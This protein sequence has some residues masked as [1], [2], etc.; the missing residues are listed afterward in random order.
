MV[1]GNGTRHG[2]GTREQKNRPRSKRASY[3]SNTENQIKEM[4]K[5]VQ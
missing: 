3:C 1:K 5:E 2:R 4:R